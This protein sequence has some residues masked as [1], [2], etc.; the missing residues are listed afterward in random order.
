MNK[1]T[2]VASIFQKD[3]L[4]ECSLE[5]LQAVARQYPSF[6][7]VQFLIAEK[8]RATGGDLYNEQLEKLSLYI[9]NPLWLDFLLN[10]YETQSM[11]SPENGNITEQ[12]T[13]ANEHQRNLPSENVSLE[14]GQIQ[15]EHREIISEQARQEPEEALPIEEENNKAQHPIINTAEQ[16]TISESRENAE[17]GEELNANPET[18]DQTNAVHQTDFSI[19][20]P[21]PKYEANPTELTFEPYHTVD[22]F[23]SQG[24]KFIPEEKPKDRFGQQLK[25]FTEWLKDMKRLPESEIIRISDTFSDDKVQQLANHS[26]SE[27]QIVTETMAE[28]WLK[29]GNKEKAIEI[30]NKLGLLNPAKSAY[31]ASLA[32]QLKNS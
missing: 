10:G 21:E 14:V 11:T 16:S 27:G 24:I 17:D 8:L 6:T 9:N 32:E 19:P 3:S 13:E 2:L 1:D 30:Y 12:V 26:I 4:D 18:S 20:L 22:Y 29:Q 5:E 15:H 23:A 7:P 28:V 25:S 31:F